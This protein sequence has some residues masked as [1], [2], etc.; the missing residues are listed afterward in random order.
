M[1]GVTSPL[2]LRLAAAVVVVVGQ[3]LR[4][5]C[6]AAAL[7]EEG[8][9]GAGSVHACLAASYTRGTLTRWQL[10]ALLSISALVAGA[11]VL[12]YAMRCDACAPLYS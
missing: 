7:E 12:R 1:V 8:G 5:L 9:R 10:G 4:P 3:S 2:S 6:A 11:G